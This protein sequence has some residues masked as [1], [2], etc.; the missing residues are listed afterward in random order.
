MSDKLDFSKLESDESLLLWEELFP[1]YAKGAEK[2]PSGKEWLFPS[3]SK[4]EEQA[5]ISDSPTVQ[6]LH[7]QI[8]SALPIDDLEGFET[9]PFGKEVSEKLGNL[10]EGEA[11]TPDLT[12]DY[13]FENDP[14]MAWL[15]E[16]IEKEEKASAKDQ[17]YWAEKFNQQNFP[18]M[19]LM[20][21]SYLGSF[22]YDLLEQH[23]MLRR[24]VRDF[25]RLLSY[26]YVN[27]LRAAGVS[28]EGIFYMRKGK[29]PENFTVH[30]KYP[31]E[32][33]GAIDFNNMVFMQ[34]KPYHDMIHQYLN[35][36]ILSDK[37]IEYPALLY[38]P[39][40]VGKI[41]IPFGM[42]TGSGG[43]NKQDR[44]VYAGFSKAAFDK[45]ALR[46]MPGR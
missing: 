38:V 23:M 17:D 1:E 8:E 40:P 36:Q 15:K 34:D 16:A 28:E 30:L 5:A 6:T 35:E 20:A 12:D 24:V 46:A 33:G 9:I 14:E 42:F 39:V 22:T 37:G 10:K 4:Q 43:K 13:L 18:G 31:L 7:N 3:E 19:D 29:L 21:V 41:Y 25:T 32:Y 45:I 2:F 11:I 44:S 26:N 27:D